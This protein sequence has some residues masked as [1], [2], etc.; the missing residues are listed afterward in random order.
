[1]HMKINCSLHNNIQVCDHFNNIARG[2]RRTKS[3]EG[4]G[5]PK[6]MTPKAVIEHI[7]E[8]APEQLSTCSTTTHPS[9]VCPI[10]MEVL[11]SPVELPCGQHVC[12]ACCKKHIVFSGQTRC[13]CCYHQTPFPRAHSIKRGGVWERDYSLNEHLSYKRGVAG[14]KMAT[15]SNYF[16]KL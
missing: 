3:H 15:G 1:M 13:P 2:G 6:G 5:R 14:P 9:L 12:S 7:D 10:C 11:Q 4:K 8:I 16:K